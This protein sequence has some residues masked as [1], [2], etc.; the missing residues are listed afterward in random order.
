M[1]NAL[2]RPTWW[3]RFKGLFVVTSPDAEQVALGADY[4][5]GSE[6]SPSYDV[7]EAMS[8]Y[9]AF[10]WVVACLQAISTDLAGLPLR[11]TRGRGKSAVVVDE[12]PLLDLLEQPGPQVSGLVFRRQAPVDLLLAGNFYAAVLGG[13]RPTGLRRLHPERT[14]IEPDPYEGVA[15]YQYD[16]LGG[17]VGFAPEDVLHAR[18]S[19]Y[20]S[21]PEGQYGQGIIRPLHEDLTT[22]LRAQRLA[23]N[24]AKRGKP[25]AIISP[26]EDG[27]TWPDKV[28]QSIKE[29]YDRM[30]REDGAVVVGG[31]VKIDLPAWSPR[32][33]EFEKVRLLA[34]DAVLAAF[35]VPPVRVGLPTANY[36]TSREQSLTYWQNL[37]GIAALLDAE[38]TRLARRYDR[39]LRVSHD[40]SKVDALQASRT[41][42]LARVQQWYLLGATPAAAAAYEG[43]DDAP[44]PEADLPAAEPEPAPEPPASRDAGALLFV[45]PAVREAPTPGF[46][47]PVAEEERAIL[48][49]AHERDVRLPAER[50]VGRAVRALLAAQAER[51]ARKLAEATAAPALLATGTDPA[52]LLVRSDATVDGLLSAIW[53]ELEERAAL[54]AAVR[55]PLRDALVRAFRST[56]ATA[57]VGG[58]AFDPSYVDN[59]VEAQLGELITNVSSTTR[60]RV[61]EL[62]AEGVAQGWS[63]AEM[64]AALLADPGFGAAR[65]LTVARTESGRSLSAG[66]HA[67]YGAMLAAGVSVRKQWLSARDGEVRDEHRELDGQTVPV[68]SLFK[69]PSTGEEAAYPGDFDRAALVCNCRC[70]T[71]P[72]TSED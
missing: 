21:G 55:G 41:E 6:A 15:S 45:V 30:L 61:R 65:A 44:V 24:L 23:S 43:F 57:G 58:L 66:N 29:A 25:V 59:A 33:M 48:W 17:R 2:A 40:F 60:A 49:R 52:G 68:D 32:D 71:V 18:L 13:A 64:Q 14:R 7:A 38:L 31:K 9:S 16:T 70:A 28:R 53:S 42:R 69:V 27:D 10:P 46:K 5:S 54:R 11:L 34:R 47:P 67:A 3:T 35:G 19:S 1:S 62:I 50:A 63:V 12:H 22:D 51:L 20:E 39:G 8:A 56:L 37:V 36:A 4:A 26:G 72:V